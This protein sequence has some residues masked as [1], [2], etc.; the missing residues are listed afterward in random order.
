MYQIAPRTRLRVLLET[1]IA[2][3]DAAREEID[4][5]FRRDKAL[6][7]KRGPKRRAEERETKERLVAINEAINA[8]KNAVAKL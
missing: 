5:R 7:K 2:A 8:M 6:W 1:S 3:S 4:A